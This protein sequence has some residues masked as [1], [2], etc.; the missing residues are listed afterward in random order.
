MTWFLGFTLVL[1]GAM[2]LFALAWARPVP[3]LEGMSAWR[4]AGGVAAFFYWQRV[5]I[6]L[7]IPAILAFLVERTVRVSATQSATG[8]LYVAT[9]F[10]LMGE[11]LSRYLYLS[12]GIPQ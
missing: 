6:G 2:G 9:I 8:L 7:V 10:V 1:R 3:A 4:I 12:L 5:G 11:L